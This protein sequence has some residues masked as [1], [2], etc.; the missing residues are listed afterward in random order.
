MGFCQGFL[1]GGAPHGWLVADKYSSTSR[2]R[3]RKCSDWN[4]GILRDARA[5]EAAGDIL[6]PAGLGFQEA[7]WRNKSL[8]ERRAKKQ[9]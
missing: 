9:K 5:V 4:K 3:I 6:P 2:C 8:M 1:P 7:A